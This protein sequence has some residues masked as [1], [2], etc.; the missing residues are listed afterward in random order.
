M[1]RHRKGSGPT[2]L[3]WRKPQ[4]NDAFLQLLQAKPPAGINIFAHYDAATGVVP[5][6]RGRDAPAAKNVVQFPPAGGTVGMSA[7]NDG[8]ET[9]T[10]SGAGY[11]NGAYQLDIPPTGDSNGRNPKWVFGRQPE[12]KG[13]D[14]IRIH[15][16]RLDDGV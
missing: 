16:F 13:Y 5:D 8:T 15:G 14:F 3:P 9:M 2:G 11:G 10:I 6:A 7:N 12:D 4:Q 1:I